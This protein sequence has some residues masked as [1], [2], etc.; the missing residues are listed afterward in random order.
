MALQ[1]RWR[2]GWQV[3]LHT[4]RE[5]VSRRNQ[6]IIRTAHSLH[7][8]VSPDLCRDAAAAIQVQRVRSGCMDPDRRS[9]E[10]A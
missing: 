6:A 2:R 10:V 4:P 8:N 7:K 9:F 3:A 5:R 1:T